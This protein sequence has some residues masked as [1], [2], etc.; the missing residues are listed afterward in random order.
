MIIPMI[1]SSTVIPTSLILAATKSLPLLPQ[2]DSYC[3]HL[4]RT[5]LEARTSDYNLRILQSNKSNKQTNSDRYRLF[6][7]K[8]NGIKDSF[9]Y[10]QQ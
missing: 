10:T 4:K 1:A 6:Q 5:D 7:I 8:R 3:I 9:P 2:L